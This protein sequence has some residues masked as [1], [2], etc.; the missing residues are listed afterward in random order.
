M[1]KAVATCRCKTCGNEFTATT[2]K[3]NRREADKWEEWAS[4][5]LTECDNCANERIKAEREA[6][7]QKC[8][9]LAKEAD[10]PELT[11]SPKQI[12]WAERIRINFYLPSMEHIEKMKASLSTYT[13]N[14]QEIIERQ[15]DIAEKLQK[16]LDELKVFATWLFSKSESTFWIDNRDWFAIPESKGIETIK[17]VFMERFKSEFIPEEI[18]EEEQ[19]REK[20]KN[21]IIEPENKSH[22]VIC[23]VTCSGNAVTVKSDYDSEMPKVVKAHGYRWNGSVWGRKM[24]YSTGS[25]EDRAIEIANALLVAGFPVKIDRELADRAVNGDY[26]SEHRRW[27]SRKPNTDRLV[28]NM[29]HDNFDLTNK[30]RRIS[31]ASNYGPLTVPVSSWEEVEEFARLYDFRFSPGATEAI[32]K[33]K[34]MTVK[35]SV[36]AGEQ[37]VYV[38]E[39]LKAILNS[40]RDVLDDLREND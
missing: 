26:T 7:A 22:A 40:S 13:E 18:R 21:T 27:V 31:G 20:E 1:A 35:T 23:V 29:E 30:A 5:H 15:P 14:R 34:S 32:D 19:A 10:L 28:I 38:E 4:E 9:E 36:K 8:A 3:Y 39:D 24:N 33:L 25:A 6:E 16:R 12:A 11:G 17:R 2:I 37:A